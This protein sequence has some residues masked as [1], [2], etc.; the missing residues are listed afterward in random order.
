MVS[1]SKLFSEVLSTVWGGKR[2]S[3]RKPLREGTEGT[4]P[5]VMGLTRKEGHPEG[6]KDIKGT[7]T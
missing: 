6:G 3:S 5:G 7:H 4:V 1:Q 2:T